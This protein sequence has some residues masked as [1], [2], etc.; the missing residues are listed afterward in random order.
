MQIMIELDPNNSTYSVLSANRSALHIAIDKGSMER[1]EKMVITDPGVINRQTKESKE[2]PLLMAIE[3]D[4][5]QA[6]TFILSKKPNLLLE[7]EDGRNVLSE[8]D[9]LSDTNL[10]ERIKMLY[11]KQQKESTLNPDTAH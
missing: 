4:N 8:L 2:F 5:A 6:V 10:Q 11:T 9:K 3:R 1:I 7:T